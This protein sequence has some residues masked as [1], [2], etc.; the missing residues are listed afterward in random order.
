MAGQGIAPY[1]IRHAEK[2]SDPIEAKEKGYFGKLPAK[3]GKISTEISGNDNEGNSYPLL[4]PGLTKAEIKSLLA[5]ERP[6]SKKIYEKAEEHAAK[7]K[8]EGKSTFASDSE[9]RYPVPEMKKG[10]TVKVKSASARADGCC[11][12]GKTRA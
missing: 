11:V 7:R 8:A 2:V 1:G 6:I 3:G 4:V 10:G 9:L 12:R 5:E